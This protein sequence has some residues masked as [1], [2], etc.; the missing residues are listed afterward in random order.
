[1]KNTKDFK[2][3]IKANPSLSGF[4]H[5]LIWDTFWAE[6]DDALAAGERANKELR[7]TNCLLEFIEPPAHRG[8][9]DKKCDRCVYD[10]CRNELTDLRGY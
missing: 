5:P 3:W 2:A 1:M 6:L 4:G 9:E 7:L 8:C 10:S